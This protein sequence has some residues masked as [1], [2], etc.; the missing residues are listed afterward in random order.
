MS[1]V[2]LPFPSEKEAVRARDVLDLALPS[3]GGEDDDGRDGRLE[4]SV[5]VSEALEIEH[6][7]LVDE[8]H[9]RHELGDPLVDVARDHLVYLLSQLVRYL[10][11]LR[12]HQLP[13]YRQ[14][15]LPTLHNITSKGFLSMNQINP[16]VLIIT[17]SQII[18][19]I[20]KLANNNVP[21][22]GICSKNIW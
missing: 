22:L 21:I 18:C 17:A 12:L 6:V 19:L 14:D 13:H 20:L 9:S 15:V 4:R 10:R 11:L 8:Q 16:Q 5:Q 7:H 2:E 3:V 1:S